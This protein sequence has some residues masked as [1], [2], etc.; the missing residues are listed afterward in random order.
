MCNT[1]AMLFLIDQLNNLNES[2]K[3]RKKK[4]CCCL[5]LVMDHMK[6][7]REL[8]VAPSQVFESVHTLFHFL[9]CC[10]RLTKAQPNENDV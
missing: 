9:L 5:N 10:L 8:D 3:K 4:K 7:I 2:K 1:T 6:G